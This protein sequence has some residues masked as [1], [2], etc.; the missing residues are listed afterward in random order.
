MRLRRHFTAAGV[1]ADI[2]HEQLLRLAGLPALNYL[3]ETPPNATVGP[4]AS[5]SEPDYLAFVGPGDFRLSLWDSRAN[6]TTHGNRIECVLGRSDP[7]GVFIPPGVVHS[8]KN[9][10]EQIGCVLNAVNHQPSRGPGERTT[11]RPS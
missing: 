3:I 4:H 6:S 5:Q 8:F 11:E 2:Y 9:I 1:V 10:G 7:Q